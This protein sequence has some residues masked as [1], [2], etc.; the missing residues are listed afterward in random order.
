MQH[1]GTRMPFW[2]RDVVGVVSVGLEAQVG[3]LRPR[4][5]DRLLYTLLRREQTIH[6]AF[7][8]TYLS[9]LCL[10]R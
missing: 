2:T 1:A 7:D 8:T 10:F 9:A 3:R 6:L 5:A 4:A